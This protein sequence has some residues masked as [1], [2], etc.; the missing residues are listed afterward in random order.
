MIILNIERRD[1]T[2]TVVFRSKVQRSFSPKPARKSAE[3]FTKV[4]KE[5]WWQLRIFKRKSYGETA[6]KPAKGFGGALCA[7]QRSP[8]F[9]AFLKFFE[10]KMQR[11]VRLQVVT[12]KLHTVS[13]RTIGRD[14]AE[15]LLGMPSPGSAFSCLNEVISNAETE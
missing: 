5:C 3:T 12:P 1:D 15:I 4:W 11:L 9:L 2:Q 13:M 10:D 8:E 6:L 7:P 14:E